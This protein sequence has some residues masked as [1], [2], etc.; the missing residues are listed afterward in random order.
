MSAVDELRAEIAHIDNEIDDLQAKRSLRVKALD[1]LTSEVQPRRRVMSAAVDP[2][3]MAREAGEGNVEAVRSLLSQTKEL[4][5]R[6]LASQLDIAPGS[7][8]KAVRALEAAGVIFRAGR[9][10]RSQVWTTDESLVP[11]G[12][13]PW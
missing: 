7:V 3:A 5:Q 13:D 11:A 10:G 8:S 9:E 4:S 2:E 6:D 12:V 1:V